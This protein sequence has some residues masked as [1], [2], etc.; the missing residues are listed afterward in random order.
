MKLYA[1]L[2]VTKI[3]GKPTPGDVKN[4]RSF[5]CRCPLGLLNVFLLQSSAPPVE[6]TDRLMSSV[7][8]GAA[9]HT[10][11]SL[12]QDSRTP[13]APRIDVTGFCTG[14]APQVKQT[15]SEARGSCAELK[16]SQVLTL[17]D[18]LERNPGVC[19]WVWSR[20]VCG[21]LGM[22]AGQRGQ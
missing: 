21:N 13:P 19:Y 20:R 22:L 2:H 8:A 12:V 17:P 16:A 1:E 9:G 11:P 15:A 5:L 10:A 7:S 4:P 18:F 3:L 14:R 6:V